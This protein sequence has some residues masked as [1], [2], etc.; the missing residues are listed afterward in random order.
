MDISQT[1][2]RAIRR[3]AWILLIPL[4]IVS[5]SA[6]GPYNPDPA[7][8]V[9]ETGGTINAKGTLAIVNAQTSA[10]LH[11][12]AMRGIQVSYKDFTESLAEAL[13][14]GFARKGVNV[15]AQGTKQIEVKVTS[16][17]IGPDGF[18]YRGH[19]FA[20]VTLGNGVMENF[21][22]TRASYTSAFNV[23]NYP[24]KPL[25]AAFEDMVQ[26]ILGNAKVSAYLGE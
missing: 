1:F 23:Q 20:D 14:I 25:D 13:R 8:A 2:R 4:A 10:G 7:K 15:S 19:I 12:L 22:T 3:H 21:H 18:T 16:V 9:A 11:E 26:A 24:T 17:S 5:C 6:V